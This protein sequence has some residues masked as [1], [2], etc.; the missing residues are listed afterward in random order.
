MKSLVNDNI[1]GL[2]KD[3][4]PTTDACHVGHTYLI[5]EVKQSLARL[6]LGWVTPMP[7]VALDTVDPCSLF[8]VQIP[9]QILWP[10]SSLRRE[11]Y[12]SASALAPLPPLPP[13]L[14]NFLHHLRLDPAAPALHLE[15]DDHSYF[16]GA[17]A[18]RL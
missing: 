5:T 14:R 6:L 8:V 7:C 18:A 12:F 4:V 2:D 16:P 17:A 11:G 3:P 9:S 1:I 13:L 10:C 15:H